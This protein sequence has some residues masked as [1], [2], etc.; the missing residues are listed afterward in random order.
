MK[1]RA[2]HRAPATGFDFPY[3]RAPVVDRA[4]PGRQSMISVGRACPIYHCSVVKAGVWG[5]AGS[6]PAAGRV[7]AK[8]TRSA[9]LL[10]RLFYPFQIHSWPVIDRRPC[11]VSADHPDPI[12]LSART[13][14]DPPVFAGPAAADSCRPFWNRPF[15]RLSFYPAV[16]ERAMARAAVRASVSVPRSSFSRTSRFS[17]A[18]LLSG[19]ILSVCS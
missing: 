17:F 12:G 6:A 19:V 3:R 4:F 16:A 14:S 9:Q 5:P 2:H 15:C 8:V 18:S 11:Q 13:V 10:P 7:R 1:C